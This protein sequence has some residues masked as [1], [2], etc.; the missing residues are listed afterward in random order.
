VYRNLLTIL[1]TVPALWLSIQVFGWIVSGDISLAGALIR[2]E[3]G[4]AK[5]WASI[6]MLAIVCLALFGVALAIFVGALIKS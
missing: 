2:R 5:F 3:V 6:T 4:P 1:V